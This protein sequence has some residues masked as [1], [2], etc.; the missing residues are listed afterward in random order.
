MGDAGENDKKGE[1]RATPAT[2][3][4]YNLIQ[5]PI[6]S[7]PGND[8]MEEVAFFTRVPFVLYVTSMNASNPKNSVP[9]RSTRIV[10]LARGKNIAAH[11]RRA[12]TSRVLL[13]FRELP[14]AL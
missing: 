10:G 4:G 6:R 11:V 2:V 9:E 3:G 14:R 13:P 12:D 8:S 7:P 5:S 1:E